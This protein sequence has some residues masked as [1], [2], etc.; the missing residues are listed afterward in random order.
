MDKFE[1][2][3]VN[4]LN[5]VSA[6]DDF[7][8]AHGIKFHTDLKE[9]MKKNNGGRPTKNIFDTEKSTGEVFGAL[10]SFNASDPDNIFDI[11][12]ILQK[13]DKNL[14]PF[15]RDPAGNY[16]CVLCGKIVFWLHETNTYENVADTFSELLCKLY[17]LEY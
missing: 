4:K 9:C 3:Y 8:Q 17:T 1:W 5:N 14:I 12:S 11:F 7:E 15:A 16:L 6:I 2:K 13:E 10:L